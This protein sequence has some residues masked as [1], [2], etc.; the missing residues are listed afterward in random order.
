MIL[1]LILL[2]ITIIICSSNHIDTFTIDDMKFI[3]CSDDDLY[4]HDDNESINIF[5]HNNKQIIDDGNRIHPMN[6]YNISMHEGTRYNKKSNGLFSELY[7]NI[8]EDNSNVFS[9]PLC[10]ASNNYEFNKSYSGLFNRVLTKPDPNEDNLN[11]L[12]PV[13]PVNPYEYLNKSIEYRHPGYIEN[14]IIYDNINIDKILSDR[15]SHLNSFK[16]RGLQYSHGKYNIQYPYNF[17]T[18]DDINYNNKFFPCKKYGMYNN[19]NASNK[20]ATD[21]EK[22]KYTC[23]LG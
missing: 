8:H 23:C 9:F 19:I 12:L 3:P 11:S 5:K 21:D 20:L 6:H 4:K 14:Q 13:D 18:C 7:D 22:H 17:S 10:N 16:S 2:C 15:R 1:I